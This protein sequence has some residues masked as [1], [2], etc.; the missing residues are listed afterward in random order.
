MGGAMETEA[1]LAHHG[2][3]GMKW[4]VR[5]DKGSSGVGTSS[6]ETKG[7]Q[8]SDYSS[9]IDTFY[10]NKSDEDLRR[11][12]EQK[13]KQQAAI[14]FPSSKVATQDSADNESGAKGGLTT[15]QKVLIGVG[16]TVAAGALV[17]YG[18]Q[19]YDNKGLREFD[20]LSAKVAADSKQKVAAKK[21]LDDKDRAS[22]ETLQNATRQETSSEWSRL[23]GGSSE[24]REFEQAASGASEGAFYRGLKTKKAL[25]RP[26]F[27]I[28]E[29]TVFQ[30]LSSTAETGKDYHLGAYSSFLTNDKAVYGSSTEFGSSPYLVSYKAKGPVKVPSTQTV[31]DTLR[32]VKKKADGSTMTADE[33]ITQY[34][35]LAGGN[36][37]AS[38]DAKNLVKA[39]KKQ[40]YSAIV[41]D[42]DAGY[43]GDLPIVFFGNAVE[44]KSQARNRSSIEE[45]KAKVIKTARIYA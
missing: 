2:V 9:A 32:S 5:N 27:T 28:P 45:D 4:G 17:Y 25:S 14:T 41:D 15:Q 26:E 33:T 13:L 20:S 11:E 23:F 44:V 24:F 22:R 29:D 19:Y 30:R 37:K 39:L 16:A 12:G 38:P 6:N 21:L 40:G 36:W 8:S 18:K 7:K 3:K 43:L 35:N 31:L 34:H 10:K 42:M 1:F